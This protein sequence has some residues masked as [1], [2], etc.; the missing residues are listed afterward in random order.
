MEQRRLTC[1]G[2]FLGRIA[3]ASPVDIFHFL[4]LLH[5]KIGFSVFL[6]QF[7]F[8][9]KAMAMTPTVDNY[10]NGHRTSDKASSFNVY[11]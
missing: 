4:A 11:H 8:P 5:H 10:M 1:E 7:Q 3:V 6:L 2:S 9:L